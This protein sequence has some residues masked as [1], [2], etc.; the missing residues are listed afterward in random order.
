MTKKYLID[1]DKTFY[2]EGSQCFFKS[3]AKEV[4]VLN[5]EQLKIFIDDYLSGSKNFINA[6]KA[7]NLQII[8]NK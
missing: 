8:K 5:D 3:D 4:E 6:L 2:K 1:E 7:N